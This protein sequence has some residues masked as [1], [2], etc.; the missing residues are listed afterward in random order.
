MY[1]GKYSNN[2]STVT[3]I[4]KEQKKKKKRVILVYYSYTP[5]KKKTFKINE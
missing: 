3:W 2:Y 5:K 4:K 1:T